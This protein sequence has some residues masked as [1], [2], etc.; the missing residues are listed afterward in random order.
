MH[1][2]IAISL[3]NSGLNEYGLPGGF[4]SLPRQ[5]ALRE[6]DSL[7]VE[8]MRDTQCQWVPG[9]GSIWAQSTKLDAPGMEVC[10]LSRCPRL[11]D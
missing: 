8:R 7:G 6:G 4:R 2:S 1:V 9:G 11:W 5:C 3:C 10:P